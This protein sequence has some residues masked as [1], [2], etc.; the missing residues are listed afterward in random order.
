[1]TDYR[2]TCPTCSAYRRSGSVE[3]TF[4]E[5]AWNRRAL[6]WLAAHTCGDGKDDGIE[7]SA[8]Y[9]QAIGEMATR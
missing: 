8:Q 2:V 9:T 3:G 6:R 5:N 4:A 1:M 7:S